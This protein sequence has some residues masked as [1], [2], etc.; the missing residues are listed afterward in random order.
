MQSIDNWVESSYH[1]S[2]SSPSPEYSLIDSN[3]IP[4][5]VCIQKIDK[6]N[7]KT[8]LVTLIDTLEKSGTGVRKT[9]LKLKSEF[10]RYK[11]ILFQ[12]V[13]RSDFFD[14]IRLNDIFGGLWSDSTI[15]FP[16]LEAIQYVYRRGIIVVDEKKQSKKVV[17][18]K[19]LKDLIDLGKLHYEQVTGITEQNKKYENLL[20]DLETNFEPI[21]RQSLR[22]L[23]ELTFTLIS[24]NFGQKSSQS[25]YKKTLKIS[26]IDM[27]KTLIRKLKEQDKQIVLDVELQ[28]ADE[29]YDIN[30]KIWKGDACNKSKKLYSEILTQR[31]IE[32]MHKTC[33]QIVRDELKKL[34]IPFI[35]E[36][37]PLSRLKHLNKLLQQVKE[38]INEDI[39]I[40]SNIDSSSSSGGPS[41]FLYKKALQVDKSM[42]MRYFLKQIT[43]KNYV[44]VCYEFIAKLES[45]T[46]KFPPLIANELFELELSTPTPSNVDCISSVDSHIEAIENLLKET[47]EFLKSDIQENIQS[48]PSFNTVEQKFV[49]TTG[50]EEKGRIVDFNIFWK[51][52][53]DD[54]LNTDM[55][56]SLHITP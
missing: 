12:R 54:L 25:G 51:Q 24:M 27:L 13:G 34:I 20:I 33:S 22:M 43:N 50:L 14:L 48:I 52:I 19:E 17:K 31:L 42:C 39:Q 37:I 7:A 46:L 55:Q 6:I 18:G 53:I 1:S 3:L 56:T 8:S 32:N 44:E 41:E 47:Y 5:L 23:K 38:T 9:L 15:S 45:D 36:D 10:N 49:D 35:N 28:I 16:L 30:I 4:H 29:S 40:L 21:I 2:S 26:L 11:A